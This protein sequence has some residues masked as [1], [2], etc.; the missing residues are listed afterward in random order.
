MEAGKRH[1]IC[2]V[3]LYCM[4]IEGRRHF[5]HEHPDKSK[6]WEMPEVQQLL[7]RP[8]VGSTTLHMC[9]FGMSAVD[10]LGTAPVKKPTIVMSTSEEVLQ[11]VSKI[12]SNE[13]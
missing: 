7:L 1:I 11:R 4:Q 5:V 10:E 2:F 9:A 6:A 3:E 8:E 12:C 13:S